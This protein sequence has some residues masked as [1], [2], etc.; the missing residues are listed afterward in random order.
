MHKIHNGCAINV[1]EIVAVWS[2]KYSDPKLD[3]D[4]Y[5]T[6]ALFRNNSTILT[7][8][9]YDSKAEADQL[10]QQLLSNK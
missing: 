10:I 3:R 4:G 1:S 9:I 2:E 5:L 6:R 7:L 8:G